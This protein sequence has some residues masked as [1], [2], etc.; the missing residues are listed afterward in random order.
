MTYITSC[1]VALKA[2]KG[3]CLRLFCGCGDYAYSKERMRDWVARNKFRLLPAAASII[4]GLA[5]WDARLG[6]LVL[7]GLLPFLHY[8]KRWR[9]LTG[10]QIIF[11]CCLAAF[12]FALIAAAWIL[13]TVPGN[14]LPIYGGAAVIAKVAVWAA[15]ALVSALSF[16]LVLGLLLLKFRA[17]G[18]NVL[19]ALPLMWALGEMGRSLALSAFLYGPGGSPGP[20]WN[21]GSLGLAAA[22]TP[23]VYLSRFVGLF[24]LTAAAV[25]VNIILYLAL[26]R[27]FRLAL[28]VAAALLAINGL[29][30]QLYLPANGRQLRVAAYNLDAE[31]PS[32]QEWRAARLP[33]R[34]TDLF[35]LPEYSNFFTLPET[36]ARALKSLGAQT[37]VVTS[38]GGRQTAPHTNDLVVYTDKGRLVSRQPKTF[39]A[40]F[41]EYIPYATTAALKLDGQQGRGILERFRQSSQIQ[42]GLQPEKPVRLGNFTLGSLVCSGTLNLNEY[43]RL[44]RQGA[45]VLTNSAS[46]ALVKEASL[47]HPYEYYQGRLH[48]VA[49][50]RPFVQATRSGYSYIFS[51][52]GTLLAGTNRKG[53]ITATV[54]LQPKQTPYSRY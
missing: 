1:I 52:D 41:G 19:P 50:A 22:S 53:L 8:L 20:D 16:G 24:G 42:K 26:G 34:D 2:E 18:A 15:V 23:L 44:T 36:K 48:A 3:N 27:R 25:M 28:A 47:Y 4:T 46:L 13:Q 49:N 38:E 30:W 9:R 17:A 43:R 11:D 45:D 37:A 31:A 12:L 39:L 14:W 32:A 10:R 21:Y 33:A 54:S 29:A 35:V 5:F 40:P 51:S 6:W 7:V